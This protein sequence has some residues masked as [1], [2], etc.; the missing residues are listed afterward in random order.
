MPDVLLKPTPATRR[1]V[2]FAGGAVLASLVVLTAMI[3]VTHFTALPPRVDR[4]TMVN[5]HPYQLNVGVSD[6]RGESQLLVGVVRRNRTAAYE[7]VIDQGPTWRFRFSY[8]GVEAGDLV[9]TRATLQQ[10]RWR[11][12]VPDLVAQRLED[13]GLEPSAP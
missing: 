1:R 8:A 2:S 10:D 13:E 12:T 4:L 5:P 11:V 6:A 3:G 7:E 9:V